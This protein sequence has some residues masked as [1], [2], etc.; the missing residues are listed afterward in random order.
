L[1]IGSGCELNSIE[2]VG[3]TYWIELGVDI[4]HYSLP[5]ISEDSLP[6]FQSKVYHF[7]CRLKVV[8]AVDHDKMGKEYTNKILVAFPVAIIE[9]AEGKDY[10]EMLKNALSFFKQRHL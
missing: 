2:T 6:V 3:F 5:L 4:T 1:V 8:I 7:D 10:N 9:Y